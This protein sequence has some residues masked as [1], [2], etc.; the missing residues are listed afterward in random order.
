MQV[1]K[2]IG[3]DLGLLDGVIMSGTVLDLGVNLYAGFKSIGQ[4]HV[5]KR[6]L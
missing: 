1:F 2:S 3:P 4:I 5:C 6:V